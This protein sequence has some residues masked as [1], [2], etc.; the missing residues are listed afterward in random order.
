MSQRTLNERQENHC[1]VLTNFVI[2]NDAK[3]NS[4]IAL[5]VGRVVDGCSTLLGRSVLGGRLDRHLGRLRG[6]GRFEI[7][8]IGESNAVRVIKDDGLFTNDTETM[9]LEKSVELLNRFVFQAATD[10][11]LLP[12]LYAPSKLGGRTTAQ[13]LVL[14]AE[15]L[16]RIVAIIAEVKANSPSCLEGKLCLRR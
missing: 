16:K 2:R 15:M 4:G 7:F 14:V 13:G 3:R 6:F 9:F 12:L 8:Q 1:T 10:L 5:I 11:V